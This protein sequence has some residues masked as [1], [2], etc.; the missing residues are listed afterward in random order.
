MASYDPKLIEYLR[1]E[2]T[3]EDLACLAGVVAVEDNGLYHYH[4]DGKGNNHE[5]LERAENPEQRFKKR[6]IGSPDT[7]EVAFESLVLSGVIE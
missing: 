2:I 5:V 1:R 4:R 3:Q 6:Y 7:A